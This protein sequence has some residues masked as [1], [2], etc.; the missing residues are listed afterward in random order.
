MSSLSISSTQQGKKAAKDSRL[1][2]DLGVLLSL[3][4][5]NSAVEE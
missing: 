2:D 4:V 5:N 3:L 1:V